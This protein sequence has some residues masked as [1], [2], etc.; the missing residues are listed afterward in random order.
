M[1]RITSSMARVALVAAFAFVAACATVSP[2]TDRSARGL[3]WEGYL[4]RNGLRSPIAVSLPPPGEAG[5]GQLTAGENAVPLEHVEVTTTRVHFELPGEGVFEG[6]VAGDSIAGSV[7][8]PANGA[9]VLSRQE[10][11]SDPYFLGP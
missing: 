9:F 2:S 7:T 3:R 1:T 6:T 11:A 10:P 5:E 8:G 4:L